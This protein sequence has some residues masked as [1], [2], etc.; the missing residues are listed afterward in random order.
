MVLLSACLKHS[1][2]TNEQNDLRDS[3]PARA[4]GASPLSSPPRRIRWRRFPMR[5]SRSPWWA[6]AHRSTWP[7]PMRRCA[8]PPA[9]AAPTRSR[10]RSIPPPGATPSCSPSPGRARRPRSCGSSSGC[11]PRAGRGSPPSPA[12]RRR[13]P[14]G[15]RSSSTSPTRS[16]W[17]RPGSR[18]HGGAPARAALGED[19]AGSPSDAERALEAPL[20]LDP[21]ASSRSFLGSGW[22]VGLAHE[23]ALKLREAARP[24]AERT[25]R[26]STGTGRSASPSQGRCVW[27][28]SA[29]P[30]GLVAQVGAT[31]ATVVDDRDWTRWSS[32]RARSGSRSRRP[33]SP[34]LDPDRPR[35]LT[36]SVDPVDQ[37]ARRPEARP[38]ELD[39]RHGASR[40]W[41]T[42]PCWWPPAR[43]AGAG[44]QHRR[45]AHR[46]AA[47]AP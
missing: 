7:G 1:L 40:R 21:G 38:Q 4:A 18:D 9:T 32:C 11:R 3:L 26:W 31:G 23:A 20:P 43:A 39:H 37:G 22:T 47:A 34:G 29:L 5:A 46:P 41:S 33:A 15:A 16:R 10:R 13:R 28:F 8:R 2:C 6:V 17:C 12:R 27:S 36:R 30:P 42:L 24:G 35:N 19:V 44:R 14:R 25:P 45:R